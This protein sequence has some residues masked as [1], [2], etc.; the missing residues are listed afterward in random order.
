VGQSI[1]APRLGALLD[2][3]RLGPGRGYFVR[4]PTRAYATRETVAHLRA[5]LAPLRG[6]F[7]GLHRVVVGDLSQQGGGVLP[8]HRSHQS[9]RDVDLGFF[10]RELPTGFP[11]KFVRG[12][13]DNLHLRAT[14]ELVRSL[15]ATADTPT[16][17]E[18]ILLDYEMQGL[19]YRWASRSGVPEAELGRL[20]QYPHG[21]DATRGLVRHYR[22]HRDHMH[23]RFKCPLDSPSCQPTPRGPPSPLPLPLPQPP[24]AAAA[25]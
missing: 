14:F 12:T 6:R 9:G 17:I 3:T 8:G 7:P 19:L 15:A 13:R 4:N 16:G 5:A 1:G 2:G 18:W 23:V 11:A 20:L 22:N 25:P 21:S 24:S 10:Y